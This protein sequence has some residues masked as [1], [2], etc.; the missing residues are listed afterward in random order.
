[1]G[2]LDNIFGRKKEAE[3]SS[4]KVAFEMPEFLLDEK[5]TNAFKVYALNLGIIKLAN[6]ISLCDFEEYYQGKKIKG[7]YWY[8][9]NYQPNI[10]QSAPDFFADIIQKMIFERNGALVYQDKKGDFHI[11]DHYTI[12]PKTNPFEE[13]RYINLSFN[14]MLAPQMELLERDVFLF[15]YHNNKIRSFI[16]SIYTEYSQI[17]SSAIKNYN[18]NNSQKI[19]V[20]IEAQ[21][22]QLY[23]E[24]IFDEDGNPVLNEDGSQ[25][26]EADLILDEIFENRFKALISDGD[27]VTPVEQG[28]KPTILGNTKGN[29]KSGT[30]TTRD[31]ADMIKDIIYFSADILSI[32]RGYMI[33]DVADA[34]AITDNYINGGVRP[35]IEVL[36]KEMNRKLYS[37]KLLASNNKLKINYFSI[38]SRDPVKFANAA[39]AYLRTGIY[40]INMILEMM[41]EETIQDEWADKRFMT[42][43]YQTMEE[44][45]ESIKE[46]V[47]AAIQQVFR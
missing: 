17:L 8:R 22:N 40:T 31:I 14:G 16:D 37:Q 18:R 10:N 7:H 15:K 21:F 32:P 25:K 42:K 34:E 2:F 19:I 47:N 28:V 33:G 27:A 3:S 4:R 1:M 30:S 26:I 45:E 23:G 9:F 35:I 29:T 12:A 41:G 5:T 20:E 43:N 13:N 36:D 24:P 11:A 38:I 6:S 46:N 39:E 44:L